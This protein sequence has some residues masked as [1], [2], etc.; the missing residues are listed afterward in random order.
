MKRKKLDP[1]LKSGPGANPT[2]VSY[3]ASV[4]I[5]ICK[6]TGSV[7]RFESKKWF[8]FT[9]KNALCSLLQRWSCS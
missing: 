6:N 3:N 2:T 7:V 9:L 8:P 1:I 5:R 4:V